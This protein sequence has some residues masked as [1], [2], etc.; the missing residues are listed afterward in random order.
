MMARVACRIICHACFGGATS[1]ADR[2]DPPVCRR[3]FGFT[4]RDAAA[5]ALSNCCGAPSRARAACGVTPL[6]RRL[7]ASPTGPLREKWCARVDASR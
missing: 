7:F 5:P 3:L 1:G 4:A 2:R 6:L